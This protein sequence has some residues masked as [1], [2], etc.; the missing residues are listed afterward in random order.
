[1]VN[2]SKVTIFVMNKRVIFNK[3]CQLGKLAIKSQEL[4][5]EGWKLETFKKP[6]K[7]TNFKQKQ[8]WLAQVSSAQQGS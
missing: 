6:G 8:D 5:H 4:S 7:N 2:R 1:M 3:I